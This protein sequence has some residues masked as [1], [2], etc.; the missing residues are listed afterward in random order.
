MDNTIRMILE[1]DATAE[2][3]LQDAS[4]DC[5]KTIEE[6]KKTAAAFDEA[7]SHQTA[8]AIFELEEETRAACEQ[9]ID[10]LQADYNEQSAKLDK[11]FTEQQE[12][13]IA[14]MRSAI[15][16]EAEA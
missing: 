3:R 15:L 8:D 2:K 14:Q 6:A 1:L 12:R 10:S 16:A 9:E 7:R 13:L 11:Q 4:A 5:V